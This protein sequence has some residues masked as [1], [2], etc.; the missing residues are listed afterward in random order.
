[1]SRA[2][3]EPAASVTGEDQYKRNHLKQELRN[4]QNSGN[5]LEV[6][7]ENPNVAWIR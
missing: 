3:F 6:L 1:L 2:F 5:W 4:N 7:A